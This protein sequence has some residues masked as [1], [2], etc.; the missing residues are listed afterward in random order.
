MKAIGTLIIVVVLAS[1]AA[2]HVDLPKGPPSKN[3]LAAPCQKCA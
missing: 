1:A 2:T 3:M